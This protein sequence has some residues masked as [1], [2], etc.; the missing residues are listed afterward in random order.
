MLR[1]LASLVV[2]PVCS[3]CDAPVA[4]A[5]TI[6][7]ACARALAALGPVRSSV[8]DLEVVSATRYEGAAR[9]LVARLKFSSRLAL[10]EVA[11]DGIVAAAAWCEVPFTEATAVPVPA[12]PS[13]QRARG[14]DTAS[15]LSSLISRRT[16]CDVRD[17]L[18][19]R[20]DRRQFGRS[21]SARLAE[22]PRIEPRRCAGE[23]PAG[24]VWIVDDVAT[25]GATLLACHR[26]LRI[27]GVSDI[28]ALTYARAI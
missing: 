20:D 19:R 12:A 8:G 24:P 11:A 18:V 23:P 3:I 2:P 22:P 17:C 7:G 13:R 5:E 21:R 10:A 27:A 9:R 1:T 26:A 16:G 14:F 28:R 6:C 4:P 15:Y 25:T